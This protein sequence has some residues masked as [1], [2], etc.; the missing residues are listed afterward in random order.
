MPT[1]KNRKNPK[2]RKKTKRGGGAPVN[3]SPKPFPLSKQPSPPE[4]Q[5]PETESLPVIYQSPDGI[6]FM[7]N[8]FVN[9]NSSLILD[10]DIT[11]D[12]QGETYSSWRVNTDEQTVYALLEPWHTTLLW[13]QLLV[14]QGAK[15][16]YKLDVEMDQDEIESYLY[17]H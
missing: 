7:Q 14:D 1:R 5:S 10:P 15:M 9:D 13:A 16:F 17:G 2:R 4:N 6:L 11:I 12:Y 8:P 3:K